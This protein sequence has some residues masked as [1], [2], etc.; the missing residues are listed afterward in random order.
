MFIVFYFLLLDTLALPS[1]SIGYTCILHTFKCTQGTH[2]KDIIIESKLLSIFF[3][4]F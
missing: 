2:G 4:E 1:I 3:A